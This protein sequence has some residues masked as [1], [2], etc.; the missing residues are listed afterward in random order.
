[1]FQCF[2]EC[3]ITYCIIVENLDKLSICGQVITSSPDLFKLA[4]LQNPHLTFTTKL[5]YDEINLVKHTNL[6]LNQQHFSLSYKYCIHSLSSHHHCN[7]QALL[8]KNIVKSS[9]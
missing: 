4:M 5:L 9:Q 6:P 1:M 7:K 8:F 3:I 2:G